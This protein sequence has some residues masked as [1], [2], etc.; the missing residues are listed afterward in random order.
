MRSEV[1]PDELTARRSDVDVRTSLPLHAKRGEGRGEGRTSRR[2][3]G[4]GGQRRPSD[5][6]FP[7]VRG[8]VGVDAHHAIATLHAKRPRRRWRVS[9]RSSCGCASRRSCSTRGR[10]PPNE[11]TA[12]RRRSPTSCDATHPSREPAAKLML[13][14]IASLQRRSLSMRSGRGDGGELAA[15]FMWMRTT[16][17]LLHARQG[18][19]RTGRR[20]RGDGHQPVRASAHVDAHHAVPASCEAGRR[21]GGDRRAGPAKAM[22]RRRAR[23]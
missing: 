15:K 14:R 16:S 23:P 1:L 10:R 8:A 9:R 13:M 4:D 12:S 3:R 11:P 5:A 2:R 22:S 17:L 7:G 6:H 20:R 19:R 18:D 21:D